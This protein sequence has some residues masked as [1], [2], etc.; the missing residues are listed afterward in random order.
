MD[1][2]ELKEKKYI[3]KVETP[4]TLD[5]EEIMD[6]VTQVGVAS[7]L[8]KEEAS[9][10]APE[11]EVKPVEGEASEPNPEPEPEVEQ[12]AETQVSKKKTKKVTVE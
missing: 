7:E 9:E 2:N 5:K 12:E 11:P 1:I 3:T 4:E 8:Y 10:P 6:W